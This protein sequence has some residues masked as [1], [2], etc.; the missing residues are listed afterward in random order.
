MVYIYI[1]L[2]P[3]SCPRSVTADIMAKESSP[4]HPLSTDQSCRQTLLDPRLI[5][6]SDVAREAHLTAEAVPPPWLRLNMT[7]KIN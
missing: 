2:S 1:Y 6:N 4:F 7:N 3:P 5:E